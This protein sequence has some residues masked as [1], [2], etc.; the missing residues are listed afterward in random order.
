MTNSILKINELT[1]EKCYAFEYPCL[2]IENY[3]GEKGYIIPFRFYKFQVCGRKDGTWDFGSSD[4]RSFEDLVKYHNEEIAKTTLMLD[5]IACINNYLRL[6]YGWPEK[7]VS[8][9]MDNPSIPVPL[10][11]SDREKQPM[12]PREKETIGEI[13][14][15]NEL[16]MNLMQSFIDQT[17]DLIR[18]YYKIEVA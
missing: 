3:K 4:I 13:H 18:D 8:Y 11:E 16:D 1:T 12:K 9:A 17:Y 6:A 14:R 2:E 7:L 15:V 10:T 5:L